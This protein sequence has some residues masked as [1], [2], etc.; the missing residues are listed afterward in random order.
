MTTAH[1]PIAA[2]TTVGAVS[3]TVASLSRSVDFYTTRLGLQL[4]KQQGDTAHLGVGA[5][6]LLVLHEIPGAQRV[7][8]T[9]GLYHFAILVPSRRALGAALKHLVDTGVPLQG[10]A[11]HLVSEAIYLAD[12]E[13]N[14]IEIYRD[15]DRAEWTIQGSEIQ[16]A[17]DPLDAQGVL[18]AAIGAP[19]DHGLAEGTRMG[20]RPSACRRHRRR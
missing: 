11:D 7:P 1:S 17:T 19:T 8:R 20:P 6:E 15:R 16:M 2:A 12:P 18:A 3:L 4:L 13:G 14:G 9:A 10:A 5:E